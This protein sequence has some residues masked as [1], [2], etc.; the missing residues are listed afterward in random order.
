[1]IT[2]LALLAGAML[3]LALGVAAVVDAY[4]Q[5]A[6]WSA[7]HGAGQ[8]RWTAMDDL[9]TARLLQHPVTPSRA[10]NGSALCSEE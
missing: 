6:A 1:M 2:V 7:R 10:R 5:T 4:R 9:Q 8:H 3:L